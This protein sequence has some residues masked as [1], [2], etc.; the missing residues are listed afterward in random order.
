[1]KKA[2][3]IDKRSNSV[4]RWR[5]ERGTTP[6]ALL[7]RLLDQPD[8]PD[9]VRRLPERD[10]SAL[11][12]HVGV[13][14]AG[15]VVAL[16]SNAQLQAALDDDIFVSEAPGAPEVMDGGR[17]A[18]WLEVLLEA[19]EEAAAARV[20]VLS[21]DYLAL[22]LS[23]MI[24]VLDATFCHLPAGQRSD[25]SY[26][27]IGEDELCGVATVELNG[28]LLVEKLDVGW[29]PVLRVLLALDQHHHDYLMRVLGR[30]ASIANEY[31]E[32]VDALL[33]VA[34]ADEVL[35]EDVRAEREQRRDQ[36]GFVDARS[37]QAFLRLARMPLSGDCDEQARDIVSRAHLRH[38]APVEHARAEVPDTQAPA[39]AEMPLLGGGREASPIAELVEPSVAVACDGQMPF[40]EAIAGLSEPV[41]SVQSARM[42]ELAYLANVLLAGARNGRRPFSPGEAAETAFAT[43]ALGAE[44]LAVDART[45]QARCMKPAAVPPRASADELLEVLRRCPA[46]LLFRKASAAL[47][48][49][50]RTWAPDG[51]VHQREDLDALLRELHAEPWPE[52]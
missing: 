38:D 30:C 27:I 31:L 13:S 52:P 3:Q 37:A 18:Q 9:L 39:Q 10:F 48:V 41:P 24:L 28:L 34:G 42:Q 22:A 47:T 51:L 12:R 26:E 45:A 19:G 36:Q 25:R 15:E 32:D 43:V 23:K 11:I 29:D 40:L 17:F 33:E 7:A 14:D 20:A 21:E 16:A 2:Y 8:L 6:T 49:G 50:A 1:M 5:A 35:E 46:D 4:E 44:L